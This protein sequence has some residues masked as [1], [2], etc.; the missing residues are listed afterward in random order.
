MCGRFTLTVSPAELLEILGVPSATAQEFTPRFNVSPG[1]D[2]LMIVQ[3]K[4]PTA[5]MA[6]WGLLPRWTKDIRIGYSMINARA[7]TLREKA[8]FK[9]LLFSQRCLIP[10]DG[11]YEWRQA[12][13]SKIPYRFTLRN[14][15][16]FAFAGLWSL[17]RSPAG[18]TIHS[19]T[20]VTTKPNEL[21]SSVHDRMPVI[22]PIEKCRIWLDPGPSKDY[23]FTSLWEPYPAGEMEMV[24]VSTMVNSSREDRPEMA[25]PITQLTLF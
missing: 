24:E 21:V 19:C 1:Q 20:I 4:G 25:E 12:G 9:D 2:I 5:R 17:W 23:P 11:F 10:A 13:K 14:R 3:E 8:A 16:V 15:K 22:L 7:E 6:R 18:E